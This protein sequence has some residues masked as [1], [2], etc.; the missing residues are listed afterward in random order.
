MSL[1]NAFECQYPDALTPP[2][3]T[4]PLA[5]FYSIAAELGAPVSRTIPRGQDISLD[6][7]Q[8]RSFWILWNW[9]TRFRQEWEVP[10]DAPSTD[11]PRH[12]AENRFYELKRPASYSEYFMPHLSCSRESFSTS[13]ARLSRKC[14]TNDA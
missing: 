12:A 6:P 5:I 7:A 1:R 13:T 2:G 8:Q 9:W 4:K 10:G 11:L 3:F 14:F